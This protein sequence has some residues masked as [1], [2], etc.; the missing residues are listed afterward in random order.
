MNQS[1]IYIILPIYNEERNLR[2]LI[3]N[4]RKAMVGRNYKFIAVNDGS[5]DQS[6]A[7][8]KE[9]QD[10]DLIIVSSVINMNVGAVFSAGIGKALQEGHDGDIVVI[11]ESDQTSE[12]SFIKKLVA[13]IEEHGRDV[14]IASRYREGGGYAGFPY[15]RKLYSYW[16]NYFMHFYFPIKGVRDYTI[17]F[18]AYRM[19]IFKKMVECYGKYGLIQSKGFVANAELLVK[20]S[21]ITNKIVEVPYIYDYQK[22]LGKSKI[23]I[24][25][26]INEYFVLVGYL[27]RIAKKFDGRKFIF[28]KNEKKKVFQETV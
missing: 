10:D 24:L 28:Q 23:N 18:R 13:P 9:L 2:N 4:A 27:K 25:R 1:T 16:A 22:K 21:L 15:F 17:F 8:L 11:M 5:D 14:T 20:V 3:L 26:T 12:V 6:F 7:I 19:N